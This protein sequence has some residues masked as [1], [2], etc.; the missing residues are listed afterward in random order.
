M[1]SSRLFALL[2]TAPMLLAPIGAPAAGPRTACDLVSLDEIRDLVGSPV[3]KFSPGSSAPAVRGEL[4]VSSC[5]YVAVDAA[6]HPVNGRGAKFSL[7]WAPKAKLEETS[8]FYAKRHAEASGIKGDVLVLAWVGS[9]A[10]GKAGD[11]PAS[12]KLLAALFKKL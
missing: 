4:T 5:T 2:L 11:W 8:E 6:G 1:T 9:P 12:Q 10:E 7:M 3:S